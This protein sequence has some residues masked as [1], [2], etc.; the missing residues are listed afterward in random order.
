MDCRVLREVSLKSDGHIHCDDSNGYTIH[1]GQVGESVNWN[2]KALLE[3]PIYQHIRSSFFKETPP[4]GDTCRKCDLFNVGGTP[5]DTLSKSIKIRIEP[6]L[7]CGLACAYCKR[8]R[9]A[10]IREGDWNLSLKR[11]EQLLSSCKKNQIDVSYLSYLGWGEPLNHPEFRQL[12]LIGKQFYP[13]M[14]QE[15]TTVAQK[16]FLETLG[17]TPIDLITI[18]CDGV[19]QESYERYR[20]HGVIENV[21]NFM[22]DSKKFKSKNTKV[23]WKYIVFSHNDTDEELLKAQQLSDLYDI[24]E[25]H[26]VLTNTNNGSKRFYAHNLN[27]FPISSGKTRVI[28]AAALQKV[29]HDLINKINNRSLNKNSLMGW[30]DKLFITNGNHLVCEG[31]LF[32]IESKL[33]SLAIRINNQSFFQAISIREIRVDVSE[34]FDNKVSKES[35]FIAQLPI[36]DGLKNELSVELLATVGEEEVRYLIPKITLDK[37]IPISML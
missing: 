2:I 29:E 23:I 8:K 17:N 34:Y 19:T 26:F 4:W 30:I 3:G 11:F 31:W 37:R 12:V 24:D 14:F 32:D 25:L 18:S 20:R 1:L 13:E 7:D 5:E 22:E 21:F 15:V 27:K 36:E 16:G 33:S 10:R 28:N 9:E 35:G 6:T